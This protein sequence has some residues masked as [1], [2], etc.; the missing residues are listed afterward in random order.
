MRKIRDGIILLLLGMSVALVACSPKGSKQQLEAE[1]T[2]ALYDRDCVVTIISD[3]GYFES[4]KMLNQLA[5]DYDMHVTVA[6]VVSFLEEHKKEWKEI[7][8]GGNVEL[9]SH[10]C[11]H[12]KMS[13]EANLERDVLKHEILD[14]IEYY[15]KNFT[16]S[17]IAFIP[18]ENT[19]CA[20]GYELL[21]E[22]G[23]YAIRQGGRGLNSLSPEEGTDGG[24]WYNLLTHGIGDVET[25]EERNQWVDQAI[26]E[27]AWLIEMWHM[28]S[29]E[30]TEGGY[31]EISL[32][33][34][35][36]HV[37]YI[38]GKEQEEKVWIASMT[39]ATK[40][41]YE[42]ENA[43]V[44]AVYDGRKITVKLVCELEG[45]NKSEFDFPLTIKIKL[46]EELN[47]VD[48]FQVKNKQIEAKEQDGN[49]YIYVEL[50][51]NASCKVVCK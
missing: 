49:R 14:S 41:I 7:E 39:D 38:S 4:G 35:E 25:T 15:Q 34:A 43:K 36:E 51:P 45:K 29:E 10:S 1:V 26:D 40:Y 9:I 23:I 5:Q 11:T 47:E 42:K 44:N 37:S 46:P 6:G 2:P 3:D 32:P 16:T 18:P 24:Q 22:A 20:E 27:K 48:N 33:M 12:T 17:P 13:E 50:T 19:M 21:K 8:Q 30:G 31:Q 28:V